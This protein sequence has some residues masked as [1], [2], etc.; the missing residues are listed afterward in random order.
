[1][2]ITIIPFSTALTNALANLRNGSS[3]ASSIARGDL[4]GSLGVALAG[5]GL[6]G[7]EYKDS[8]MMCR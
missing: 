5:L 2:L 1:M 6:G 7:L 8:E 4:S 3:V